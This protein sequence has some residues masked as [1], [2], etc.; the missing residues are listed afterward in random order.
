[1]V[2]L[3][4]QGNS[5]MVSVAEILGI[6]STTPE[7]SS[8]KKVSRNGDALRQIRVNTTVAVFVADSAVRA[9]KAPTTQENLQE[10]ANE[11][12]TKNDSMNVL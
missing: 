12:Q 4:T 10:G 8:V 6:R 1:M 7:S 3:L 9:R 2:L 5:A 11:R